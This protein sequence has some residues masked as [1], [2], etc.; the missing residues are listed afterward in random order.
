MQVF[1]CS[2]GKLS[3]NT[4]SWDGKPWT[5]GQEVDLRTAVSQPGQPLPGLTTLLS[6]S[7]SYCEMQALE[8]CRDREVWALLRKPTKAPWDQASL[9]DQGSDAS[10]NTTHDFLE[11][12]SFQLPPPHGLGL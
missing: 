6:L 9:C 3:L 1:I 12:A 4:C 8:R 7:F 11:R 5:G 10:L 2:S